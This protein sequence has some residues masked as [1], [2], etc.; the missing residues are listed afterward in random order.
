MIEHIEARLGAAGYARYEIS[1]HAQPGRRSRHNARYWQRHAVLGLGMG[2]H[3]FEARV[4]DHPHG[5]R[6]ANPRSLEAWL[7]TVE[8]DPVRAGEVEELTPETARG[9]A[10]FLALRQVEGLAA[11]GFE[12]EFGG[13]PRRF[14]EAEIERASAQGW[15][16]EAANGDLRLTPA[17][18][19]LADSV[20]ALFVEAEGD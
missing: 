9:E 2:A 8:A 13:P 1:S 12:A 17:G 10:V 15:L 4:P 11:A 7:G 6:R 5:R 18:R 16:A 14:F 3:S 19:L 20:A